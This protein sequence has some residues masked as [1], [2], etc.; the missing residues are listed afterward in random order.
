MVFHAVALRLNALAF[1]SLAITQAK[2]IVMQFKSAVKIGRI[3]F[4]S[5]MFGRCAV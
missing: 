5:A 4:N 3:L 1:L 2:L